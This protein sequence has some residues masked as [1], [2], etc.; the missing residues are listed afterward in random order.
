MGIVQD[1]PKY[2]VIDRAPS[3][4]TTVSN[5]N[6]TDYRDWAAITA[7][8]VPIGWYAGMSAAKSVAKPCA[9]IAA[10]MGAWGGFCWACQ[11]STGRLMGFKENP[12]EVKRAGRR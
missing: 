9:Y 4:A 1:T 11:S 3:L 12:E 6:V 2:P 5:F 7:A 10:A 8:G